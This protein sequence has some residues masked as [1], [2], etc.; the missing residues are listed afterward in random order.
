ALGGRVA[1][2]GDHL[3]R[4]VGRPNARDVRR[5]RIGDVPAAGRD[6]EHAPIFLRLGQRDEAFEALALRRRLAREI[7]CGVA[8]ELLLNEGAH[9]CPPLA[10]VGGADR[11]ALAATMSWDA[12][13]LPGISWFVQP[14]GAQLS[15]IIVGCGV[16]TSFRRWSGRPREPG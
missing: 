6:V 1:H 5:E 7:A 15:P 14:R 3:G 8:A 10:M 11:R 9:L 2:L 16:A 12:R 13:G 4:D